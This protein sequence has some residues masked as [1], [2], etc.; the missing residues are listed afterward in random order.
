VAL[1]ILTDTNMGCVEIGVNNPEIL[2]G[3]KDEGKIS[4]NIEL[5]KLLEMVPL[6]QES[7]P[8]FCTGKLIYCQSY[9]H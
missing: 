5:E 7:T 3:T 9:W 2:K 4:V 1:I 8:E 6:L